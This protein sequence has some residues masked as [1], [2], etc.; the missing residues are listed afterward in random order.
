MLLVEVAREGRMSEQREPDEVFVEYG[1]F[2]AGAKGRPARMFVAGV[3][4]ASLA[5]MV[6]YMLVWM[7]SSAERATMNSPPAA[8]KTRPNAS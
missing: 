3:V 7:T 2:K 4:A 8:I 1:E 6:I 5:I